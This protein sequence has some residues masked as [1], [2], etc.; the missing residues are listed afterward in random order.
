[1]S[2]TWSTEVGM[3]VLFSL[4]SLFS[5]DRQAAVVFHKCGSKAKLWVICSNWR[6]SESFMVVMK[7]EGVNWIVVITYVLRVTPYRLK[8]FLECGQ[9]RFFPELVSYSPC[10]WWVIT[11]KWLWIYCSA[12]AHPVAVPAVHEPSRHDRGPQ[13]SHKLSHFSAPSDNCH[14][15]DSCTRNHCDGI[16]GPSTEVYAT[17]IVHYGHWSKVR[18]GS[19]QSFAGRERSAYP[20]ILSPSLACPRIARQIWLSYSKLQM[21]QRKVPPP[22]S[23]WTGCAN[24]A[25]CHYSPRGTPIS[26]HIVC[27][28][29]T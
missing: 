28:A 22:A 4:H 19:E 9:Y 11:C 21:F 24:S 2:A 5:N 7:I 16:W 12:S 25:M 27:E 29:V 10:Q 18:H 8:H 6:Q 23:G 26:R 15:Y 14:Y 1:M 13:L 20:S 17:P 3:T